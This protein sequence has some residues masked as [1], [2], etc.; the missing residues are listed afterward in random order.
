MAQRQ[1]RKFVNG[2][3]A[4]RVWADGKNELFGIGIKKD[5]F[6]RN[7]QAIPADSTGF[8][9]LTLGSQKTDYDKFSLWLKDEQQ[10]NSNSYSNNRSTQTPPPPPPTSSNLPPSDDDDLPF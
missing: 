5:E 3:F 8:I 4:R 6:I 7:I 9:N 2:L 10:N 1:D